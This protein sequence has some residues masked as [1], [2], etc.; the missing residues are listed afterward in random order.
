MVPSV[1]LLL[2]PAILIM[3]HARSVQNAV[4]HRGA[5]CTAT[6]PIRHTHAAH[7]SQYSLLHS[8][9]VPTVQL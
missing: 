5:E 2:P 3:A 6:A 1:Q 8:I 4:Q 7:A 9:I